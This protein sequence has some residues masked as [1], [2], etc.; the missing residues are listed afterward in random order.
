MHNSPRAKLLTLQYGTA[1]NAAATEL[2]IKIR[3][4][5][6]FEEELTNLKWAYN[7]P[8]SRI[9]DQFIINE[10]MTPREFSIATA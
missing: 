5:F 8:E 2:T 4:G 1:E 3:N 7:V 6:N 9:I 10:G